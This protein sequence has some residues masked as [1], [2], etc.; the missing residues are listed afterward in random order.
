MPMNKTPI[1]AI[2]SLNLYEK[3]GIAEVR[4]VNQSL[5]YAFLVELDSI[6]KKDRAAGSA[7]I[8]RIK[9]IIGNKVASIENSR[10]GDNFVMK[11]AAN[12]IDVVNWVKNIGLKRFFINC[13]DESMA[14]N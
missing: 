3:D 10:T 12:P 13:L 4:R 5:S 2:C 14:V 9:I 1:T 7:L 6:L 8:E 11:S